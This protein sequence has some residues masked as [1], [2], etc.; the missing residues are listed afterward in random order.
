ML[1][2]ENL[3]R[4]TAFY[5]MVINEDLL[6]QYGADE[7]D[8][9]AD[10]FLFEENSPPKNYFQ[11]KKGRVKLNN[12]HEDGKEF[13]HSLPSAGHCIGETFLFSEK[14][15]PLNAVTMEDCRILK[16]D[17]NKFYEMIDH[18]PK[19]LYDLYSFTAD[20]MY[21][22][23]KMLNSLSEANPVSKLRGLMDCLKQYYDTEQPYSYQIPFTRQQMASL[24]G[25]RIETVIRA[26][27]KMEKE[28]IVKIQNRKIF[29]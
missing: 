20:R 4:Q 17:K 14:Y 15:Y 16:L 10:E 27:K 7:I 1:F 19:L 5:F 11:I 23:Y 29:Y 21:Y 22:R 12:Y 13:I 25:L 18:H 3:S 8:Y 24:T 28:N 9:Y 26:V 6:L 2:S